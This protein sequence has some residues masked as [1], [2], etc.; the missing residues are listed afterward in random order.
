MCGIRKL[1]VNYMAWTDE[2]ILWKLLEM[3]VLEKHLQEVRVTISAWIT[4][5]WHRS[6]KNSQEESGKNGFCRVRIWNEPP[7]DKTNKMACAPSEDSIWSVFAV[8]MKKAWVLSYTLSAQRRLWS[9]WVDA[10][11]DLCTSSVVPIIWAS[12]TETL[13]LGFSDQ[14]RL[15]PACSA[16]EA[17]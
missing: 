1:Y 10:Q 7:H 3:S 11:A 14:V 2:C 9:D 13:F 6:Y 12:S 4:C 8:R 15:K 17:S 16:S 5:F